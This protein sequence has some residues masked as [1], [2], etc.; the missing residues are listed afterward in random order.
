MRILNYSFFITKEFEMKN[1]KD[2]EEF[3][4]EINQKK[5]DVLL[6][7]FSYYLDV[8]LIKYY[9]DGYIIFLSNICDNLYYKK[10]LE[11]GDFCYLYDDYQ[12]IILRL[13]YLKKKILKRDI[14]RFEN[15]IYNFRTKSLYLKNQLV[16]LTKAENEVL[17]FLMRNR[18][19]FVSKEEFIENS[20]FIEHIDSIKVI[21][22]NL[23]KKGLNII[24]KKNLG[25]KLNIKEIK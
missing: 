16:D 1:V 13:H 22:S 6:V 17:Y 23:R 25:Y 3:F 15:I 12:K 19:R 8:K 5:Y 2:K 11:I 21:I 18:N 7:D 4:D 24:N 20:D 9:F 14:I 10:A